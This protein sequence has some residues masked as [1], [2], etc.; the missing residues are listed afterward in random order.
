MEL[1]MRNVLK[2]MSKDTMRVILQEA[3]QEESNILC[4]AMK[5]KR[6]KFLLYFQ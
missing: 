2:S 3:W 5:M 4:N 1:E 6:K